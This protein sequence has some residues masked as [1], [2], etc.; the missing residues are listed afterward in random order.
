MHLMF[1][2]FDFVFLRFRISHCMKVSQR[3]AVPGAMQVL[4]EGPRATLAV[5]LE[6]ARPISTTLN[7][8]PIGRDP[9]GPY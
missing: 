9:P 2:V 4:L 6:G 3:K 1:Y 7:L 5:A 8:T